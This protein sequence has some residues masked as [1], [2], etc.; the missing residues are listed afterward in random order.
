[1]HQCSACHTKIKDSECMQCCVCVAYYH[2]I[3]VA[4]SPAQLKNLSTEVKADWL[5]PECKNKKPRSDNSNTPV[6][7]STPSNPKANVTL[8]RKGPDSLLE[9]DAGTSFNVSRSELRVIIQEEMRVIMEECV[10]DLKA[11]LNRQLQAFRGE[12]TGLTESI[13]FMSDSFEQCKKDLSGCK[14]KI[15]T[16]IKEKETLQSDLIIITS[17]LNQMEQI[18]RASNLEIQCVPEH[19]QT[20]VAALRKDLL[21]A[22]S[23]I[24]NMV[25]KIEKIEENV[26][27]FESCRI[28]S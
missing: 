19:I 13:Q 18:S 1:M 22:E 28:Q 24:A 12:I 5:C 26:S 16:I 3:C 15:D 8:R 20:T 14:T 17:R 25:E 7:P 11:D 6:R 4:I 27:S 23:A 10:R 2:C 9:S 21:L